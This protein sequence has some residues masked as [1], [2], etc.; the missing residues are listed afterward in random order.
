[1]RLV[2]VLLVVIGCG[3]FDFD[4]QARV[5][6]ASHGPADAG[7][8]D[9][10]LD[11]SLVA[12]WRMIALVPVAGGN[13][14]VDS[15][16]IT[17]SPASCGGATCPTIVAGG[18]DG[19]D[20]TEFDGAATMLAAASAIP[21]LDETF[22]IA[23]WVNN[24]TANGGCYMT[25]GLGS[26]FFNSWALCND[27]TN[28]QLFFYTC[29]GSAEDTLQPGNVVPTG[30]WHHVA[31]TWD[32][33]SK[34]LYLDG[35]KLGDSQPTGVSYDYDSVFIGGDVDSGAPTSFLPGQLDDV[36]VYNRALSASEIAALA[37]Q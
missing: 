6:D 3:R 31:G 22:T 2:Y 32:G 17:M 23:A 20:A 19:L 27:N 14:V 12:W 4:P 34:T 36:R 33:T 5:F 9:A 11:P 35:N 28:N 30:S 1:M 21:L 24:A 26:G 25:K 8:R 13:G 29:N 7:P 15:T 37:A 10:P 16:G 18:H